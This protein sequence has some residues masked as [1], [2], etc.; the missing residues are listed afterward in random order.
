[1]L[2]SILATV[3]FATSLLIT[4]KQESVCKQKLKT[5]L[6]FSL[7]FYV[8]QQH[9]GQMCLQFQL[10]FVF[11]IRNWKIQNLNLQIKFFTISEN[12]SWT[13]NTDHYWCRSLMPCLLYQ[14]PIWLSKVMLYFPKEWSKSKMWNNAWNNLQLKVFQVAPVWLV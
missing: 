8:G 11:K 5:G 4:K 2:L 10:N 6:L 14:F 13:H 9:Y 7:W 3:A 12:E 1:M